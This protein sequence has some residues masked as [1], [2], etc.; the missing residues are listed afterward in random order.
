MSLPLAEA[1]Y[2]RV[3]YVIGIAAI[4][5]LLAWFALMMDARR[6]SPPEAS[7]PV[8]PGFSASVGDATLITIQTK[9]AIYRIART[10]RGWALRDK[11]D[12]PV[13][14]ER[15][16]QFADGLAG[17]HYVR[18][19]TRDPDKLER[20]G[21][22]D[23]KKG[24]E[25]VLVQVQDAK[26]ALLANLVLGIE[27]RGLY[28]RKPDDT[29][30]WAVKG[31]LPPLKDPAAW[32]D[33]APITLDPARIARVDVA[34]PEG[35][36]YAVKRETRTQRDFALDRP[37][38][39][40]IVLTPVGLNA[41]GAS[42]AQLAPIDVAAAPAITGALRARVVTR[43]FDGLVIESELHQIGTRYWVKLIA[44]GENEEAMKEAAAINARAGP[45]AY[46]LT[47]LSF[48][49]FA[50]PLGLI[51]RSRAAALPAPAPAAP[52]APAP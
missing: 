39:D 32:L 50:P 9:D 43:T 16:A 18:P 29:Q 21:L 10:D 1:R 45:W 28:V 15:L 2:Q 19:M 42:V 22:G 20:L 24:G 35:P 13:R 17:L 36:S 46:G 14:R 51:A 40:F 49:D 41:V 5:T 23:P 25:G 38:Q 7:G 12:Y 26:G 30:S 3:A 37:F 4:V 48:R 34:P 52:P 33:L 8:L 44:R 47:E 31:E 6:L 11:G 27:P